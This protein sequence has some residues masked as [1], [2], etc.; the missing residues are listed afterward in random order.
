[1]LST[2]A[3]RWRPAVESGRVARR[4]ERQREAKGQWRWSGATRGAVLQAGGGRAGPPWRRRRCT[5]A[6]TG[7]AE[8][9][10]GG[11]RKRTSL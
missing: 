6:A 7:E 1:M 8:R 2:A 4:G 9:Q 5:A 3:A 10:A 11:G